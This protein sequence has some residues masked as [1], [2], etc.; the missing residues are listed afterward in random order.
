[1]GEPV[2]CTLFEEVSGVEGDEATGRGSM[3]V[4]ESPKVDANVV[5]QLTKGEVYVIA[6]GKAYQV[7][8]MPVR[9]GD[10]EIADAEVYV[11][12]QIPASPAQPVSIT[13]PLTSVPPSSE[14][15]P[16]VTEKSPSDPTSP[17]EKDVRHE[18][19]DDI[20]T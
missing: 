5:R 17:A 12:Q 2:P 20:L 14:P 8:V 3:R 18:P 10:T 7:R 4:V 13:P 9:V 19:D 15:T 6:H 16:T 11:R 1:M